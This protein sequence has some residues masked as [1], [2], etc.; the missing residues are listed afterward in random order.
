MKAGPLAL[1][2][3][4]VA[5]LTAMDS[6]VKALAPQFGTA[7]LVLARFAGTALWIGLWVAWL[8]PGTWPNLRRLRVHALRAAFTLASNAF[9]FFALARLPIAD[10]FALALTGPLFVAVLGVLLLN[11]ALRPATIGALLCGFAG[12]IVIIADKLVGLGSADLLGLGSAIAAPVSYAFSLVLLRAQTAHEP[13]PVIVLV[14]ALMITL[15][16]S[17]L[18][19]WQWVSPGPVQALMLVLIGLFGAVGF[20]LFVH[21]I[22]RLPAAEASSVEYTGLLWAAAIGWLV[23]NESPS[24]MLWAG[25][26]LIVAGG[27]LLMRARVAR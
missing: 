7:Q 24:P 20:L 16:L 11:E 22:A 10:V 12:A 14:Q 18:A 17:P 1:A 21:A 25:A 4:G 6:L 27:M 2:V 23:F 5:L 13:P 26:A 19:A 3:A 15:V 9:F 8:R